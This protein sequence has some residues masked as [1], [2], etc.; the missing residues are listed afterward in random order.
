MTTL[1]NNQNFRSSV[2]SNFTS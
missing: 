2:R 1:E